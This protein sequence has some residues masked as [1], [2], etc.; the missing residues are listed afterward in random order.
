MTAAWRGQLHHGCGG[1]RFPGA[2]HLFR[3]WGAVRQRQF[4]YGRGQF[5][6]EKRHPVYSGGKPEAADRDGP[7]YREISNLMLNKTEPYV[8]AAPSLTRRECTLTA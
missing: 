3:L 8:A 2:G 1:G 7:G 6:V 5:A 4:V